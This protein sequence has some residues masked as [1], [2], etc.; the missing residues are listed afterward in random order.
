MSKRTLMSRRVILRGLLQGIGVAVAL[1]PLEAMLNTSGTAYADNTAIPNRFGLWSWGNGMKPAFYLPSTPGTAWQS[2]PPPTLQPFGQPTADGLPGAI[3]Y[4]SLVS[5]TWVPFPFNWAHATS[6]VGL[7][8]ASQP[9]DQNGAPDYT[10]GGFPS[11]A[12]GPY[13]I[14]LITQALGGA[15]PFNRIDV[16]ISRQVSGADY[17]QG[18]PNSATFSPQALFN[19]LF[20]GFTPGMTAADPSVAQAVVTSKKSILDAISQDTRDLQRKLGA[21]DK[22]RLDQHLTN[23][24]A[25]EQG[26]MVAPPPT[27]SV[28]TLPQD[29]GARPP[30]PS[31]GSE[32]ME[33]VNKAMSDMLAYAF[34]CDRTRVFNVTYAPMQS[35]CHFTQVGISEGHHGLGHTEPGDQPLCAKDRSVRDEESFVPHRKAE[36]HSYGRLDQP[37]RP[38]L[39]LGNVRDRRAQLA[40]LPEHPPPRHRASRRRI[41]RRRLRRRG[42]RPQLVQ[43][44]QQAHRAQLVRRADHDARRGN[45]P[46]QLW[47]RSGRVDDHHARPLKPRVEAAQVM[48]T[49]DRKA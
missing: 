22:A 6:W 25:I 21:A 13:A 23:I 48:G 7:M 1:P 44:L 41:E 12:Q 15:T 30:D 2:A 19:K 26:L 27:T 49:H 28:C 34:A 46:G 36:E 11:Q 33:Q 31:D 4:V 10:T 16:G 14:D 32:P 35:E 47:S 40:R 20:M 24:A 39:H 8:T 5:N 42:R 29:P 3:E 17:K 9:L 43:P 38:Q 37:S 45:E 18:D